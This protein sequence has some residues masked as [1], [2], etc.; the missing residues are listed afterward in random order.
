MQNEHA[1]VDLIGDL[2]SALA[3]TLA[4]TLATLSDG[5]TTHILVSTKHASAST[6]DGLAA[7]ER[8]V[9]SAR[10]AGCSIAID[11]GNRRMRAAFANARI[12]CGVPI[13]AASYRRHLMIARHAQAPR[14][15]GKNAPAV[16]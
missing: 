14:A 9:A 10:A 15:A 1:V 12:V 4:D 6:D 13:D 16:A 2:D 8:A 7:F 11:P 5:G 3:S